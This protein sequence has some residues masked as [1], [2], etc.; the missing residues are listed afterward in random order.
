MID[1]YAAEELGGNHEWKTNFRGK[2]GQ[3]ILAAVTHRVPTMAKD[4]GIS[5]EEMGTISAQR[6]ALASSLT[7][8]AKRSEAIDLFAS[9]TEKDIAALKPLIDKASPTGPLFMNKPLNDLKRQFQNDPTLAK[10]D[11]QAIQVGTEFERLMT[12]GGLSQG[13]LHQ[14]AAEDA[15]KLINGDFAPKIAYAKLEQM[16]V[17][18]KNQRDAGHEATQRIGGQLTNLGKHEG[19]GGK[20]YATAKDA[21]AAAAKGEIKVGDTI[22]IGGKPHKVEP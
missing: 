8:V 11:Q 16:A 2:E 10:L 3:A 9:K 13:Q 15:K 20:S 22:M 18:I 17:E 14:G 7:A 21:E 19:G 5:P 1:F 12:S 4:A 6:K